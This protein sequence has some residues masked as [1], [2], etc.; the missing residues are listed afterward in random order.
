M[1]PFILPHG[2]GKATDFPWGVQK[3]RLGGIVLLCRIGQDERLLV[4]SRRFCHEGVGT[5]GPAFAARKAEGFNILT[6][7]ATKI[8]MASSLQQLVAFARQPNPAFVCTNGGRSDKTKRS[9]VAGVCHV[10]NAAAS[11]KDLALM[12][13]LRYSD[14][15]TSIQWIPESFTVG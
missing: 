4:L 6:S 12:H 2:P 1:Q 10:L 9:F 15:K 8:S 3:L 13:T 7:S 5:A 11:P 14:G